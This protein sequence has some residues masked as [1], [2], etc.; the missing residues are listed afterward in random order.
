MREFIMN[1]VCYSCVN[2]RFVTGQE[3]CRNITVF[4]FA[5]VTTNSKCDY[6]YIDS[7]FIACD[8]TRNYR[9]TYTVPRNTVCLQSTYLQGE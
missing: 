2:L 8:Y 5:T 1:F 9:F 3:S 6:L 4:T 7:L